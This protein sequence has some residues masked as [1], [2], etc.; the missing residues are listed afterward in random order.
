MVLYVV[1]RTEVMSYLQLLLKRLAL[2]WSQVS[3]G[4]GFC[5]VDS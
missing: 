5:V 4:L 3:M 2:H 1:P